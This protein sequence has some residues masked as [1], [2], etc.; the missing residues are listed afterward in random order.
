[1]SGAISGKLSCL[2]SIHTLMTR[3]V[4]GINISG[5]KACWHT[6]LALQI[7]KYDPGRP[8]SLSVDA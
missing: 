6:L 2:S 8:Y 1:M 5:S 7:S 3:A 4:T